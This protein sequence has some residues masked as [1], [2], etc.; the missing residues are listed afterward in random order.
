MKR[1]FHIICALTLL[2]PILAGCG[3]VPADEND[4]DIGNI[5]PVNTGEPDAEPSPTVSSGSGEDDYE[6]EWWELDVVRV[7]D[8]LVPDPSQTGDLNLFLLYDPDTFRFTPVINRYRVI[9]PNVNLTVESAMGDYEAYSTRLST[10]LMAGTGPDL[11]S[12]C[13][14]ENADILKL[15]EAGVFM[16]L[17]VL[18]ESDKDFNLDDYVGAVMDGGVLNGKRY[19]IPHNFLIRK[20]LYLPSRLESLGFDETK[21]ND[22]ASF[23]NELVRTLPKASELGSFISMY[24]GNIFFHVF[25][26]SGIRIIDA[27]TK[28]IL[29]DEKQLEEYIKAYKPYYNYDFFAY[30]EIEWWHETIAAYLNSRMIIFDRIASS[31]TFITHAGSIKKFGEYQLHAMP[32]IN[33]ENPVVIANVLAIREGSPNVQNAWNFIKLILSEENQGRRHF[34]L[35]PVHKDSIFLQIKSTYENFK[36]DFTEMSN[37]EFEM[38]YSL[39]TGVTKW[40]FYERY[41]KINFLFD[42][43][44]P[45]FKDEISYEDAV[46][47]LKNDLRLYLSE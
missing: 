36:D 31:I 22:P 44:E 17:N 39:V 43:F 27:E 12:P 37:E 14:M 20:F 35:T 33:G 41:Y 5:P 45:Y 8:D 47:R 7:P 11:F 9:Y 40:S 42:Y 3:D 23:L 46:A 28:T 38:Y 2:L 19:L 10:E 30:S 18:I 32:H 24:N 1:F 16:D 4:F 15:A 21:I 25:E 34:Q 29:P 26:T 13:Q 6:Y